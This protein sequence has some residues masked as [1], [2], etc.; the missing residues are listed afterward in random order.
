MEWVEVRGRSVDIAVEAALQEL[1]LAQ[2][3]VDVE[4]LQE[5]DKGFLGIGARDAVVRVKPKPKGR[6][7]R[8]RSRGRKGG[9]RRREPSAQKGQNDRQR[10]GKERAKTVSAQ[11]DNAKQ[12]DEKGPD[13]DQQAAVVGEFLEGLLE[14]FGLEG[15]VAT[16]VEDEAIYADVTGPQTEALVGVK[17]EIMQA[18]HELVRT[19]VQRKTHAGA[20]I[21]LDIAGYIERRRE[22]LRIYAERLAQRVLEEG[23]EIM[24]EPMNPAD[25]KV[26]H[27]AL[28]EIEGVRTHSEGEEPNRSVVIALAPGADA[29][30]ES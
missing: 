29:G 4:I 7:R 21:R 14:A 28:A 22:A 10:R 1:G 17:G 26:V 30:A 12:D 13:I 8:R 27:D 11:Q 15:Q 16:R 19:V 24:L 2:D 23:V 18:I 25:R 3:Q 5:P 9:E 6:S 20:R